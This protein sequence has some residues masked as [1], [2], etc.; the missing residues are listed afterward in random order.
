[1]NNGSQNNLG[2]RKKKKKRVSSTIIIHLQVQD[3]VGV[4]VPVPPRAAVWRSNRGRAEGLLLAIEALQL[5]VWHS[6]KYCSK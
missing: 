6:S 5:Y 4:P 1:M 2:Q 3:L